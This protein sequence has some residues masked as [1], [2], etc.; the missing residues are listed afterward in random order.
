MATYTN[1]SFIKN[2][3]VMEGKFLDVNKLPTIQASPY[4]EDYVIPQQYDERPDLLAYQLY[5]SSRLWWVFAMRNLD[6]IRDPIRDFKAGKTIKLPAENIVLRF[7]G[8]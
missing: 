6:E 4:D 1:E 7:R 5:E 2:F 3:S 8:R